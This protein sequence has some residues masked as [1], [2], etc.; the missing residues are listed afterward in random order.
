[1]IFL[2]FSL[3]FSTLTFAQFSPVKWSHEANK[4]D[5]QEYELVFTAEVSDG[6]YVYSQFME[7][8]GPIP[9]SFVFNDNPAIELVGKTE[10]FGNKKEAFD[11]LFEMDVIKFTGQTTFK[12]RIK[13]KGDAQEIKGYLTFMTCNGENCLPP[14]DVNFSFDL[15]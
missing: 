1:M 4:I 2:T 3:I 10:E 6:W 9:T 5:K 14:K 8:G 15:K 11:E 13:L 7:E 12:Q